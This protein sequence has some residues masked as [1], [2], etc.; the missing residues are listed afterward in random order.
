MRVHYERVPLRRFAEGGEV[1]AFDP[2]AASA[3]IAPA[4]PTPVGSAALQGVVN[5]ILAPGR[6]AQQ[7]QP[8]AGEMWSDEDEAIR[9]ANAAGE[10]DWGAATALNM[11]GTPGGAGGLGSGIR[12]YHGSPHNF[13]RFDLSKAGTGEGAQAYGHGIYVAENPAVARQYKVGLSDATVGGVPYD[14]NNPVHVAASLMDE[15]GGKEAAINEL[16]QRAARDPGDFFQQ[17]ANYLQ[18]GRPVPEFKSAGHMYEVNINADPEHFLDWDKPVSE[19]PQTVKDVWEK[20]FSGDGNG[21][22][23][24]DIPATEGA[25]VPDA[26]SGEEIWRQIV[27]NQPRPFGTP[28]VGGFNPASAAEQ[29]RQ[30]GIPGIRYLDQG[31]RGSGAGTRNYVLFDDSLINIIRKYGIAGLIA[32]GAAHFKMPTDNNQD[33]ARGGAAQADDAALTDEDRAALVR[34]YREHV[35]D[36]AYRGQTHY[37][38]PPVRGMAPPGSFRIPR[39]VIDALGDGDPKTGGAVAHGMFGLEDDPEDPTIIH[40]NVVRLLGNG[41]LA[42]GR[43]VLERFVQRVRHGDRE[44]VV[45]EHDVSAMENG[46]HGWRVAR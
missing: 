41:S 7:K 39:D 5:Q 2:L 30:A 3:G 45:L 26:R 1:D 38:M 22:R 24:A 34:W 37:T 21:P 44:G 14:L 13:E 32:G 9:Q 6:V 16:N 29:L 10:G 31:S 42:A 36:K 11:V 19:Q 12:A 17:A 18:S 28:G 46:H 23:R 20:L 8:Q 25:Y 4:G 27:S 33:F 15:L 40:G 43:R 35:E